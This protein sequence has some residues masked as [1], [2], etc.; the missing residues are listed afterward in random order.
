MREMALSEILR[1]KQFYI[2]TSRIKNVSIKA[3][4]RAGPVRSDDQIPTDILISE[5]KNSSDWKEQA[6]A[7]ELL[8]NRREKNVPQALLE[9]V[10]ENPVLDVVKVALNSFEAVTG[11]KSS[12][13]FDCRAA[14]SWWKENK[15]RVIGQLS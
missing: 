7:A 6:K 10:C 3:S 8:A 12:D 1:V 9:S 5:L 11:Y 2:T 4:D 14:T 13:V 15:Q